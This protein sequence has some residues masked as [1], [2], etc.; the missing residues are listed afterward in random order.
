VAVGEAELDHRGARRLGRVEEIVWYLVAAVSY[1][2]FGIFHKFLLNWFI[3]P[4]WLVGV[5][6]LGPLASDVVRGRRRRRR[7]AA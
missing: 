6:V 5:V 3:G 1:I 4:L 2:G 7:S